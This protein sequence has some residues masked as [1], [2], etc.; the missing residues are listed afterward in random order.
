MLL[1]DDEKINLSNGLLVLGYGDAEN[2]GW[3][4]A[5]PTRDMRRAYYTPMLLTLQPNIELGQKGFFSTNFS[6]Y[7][8]KFA[9]SLDSL[10]LS[11]RTD[12][13]YLQENEQVNLTSGIVSVSEK[14]NAEFRVFATN[15]KKLNKNYFSDLGIILNFGNFSGHK[16]LPQEARN[17]SPLYGPLSLAMNGK[18]NLIEGPVKELYGF[19]NDCFN[20]FKKIADTLPLNN[21]RIFPMVHVDNS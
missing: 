12:S 3:Y 18:E 5:G 2:N 21:H 1:L 11:N 13:L 10:N 6:E 4:G 8:N 16:F 7:I 9:N 19:L 15:I 14:E 17:G 20:K